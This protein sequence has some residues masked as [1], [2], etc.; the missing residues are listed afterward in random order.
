MDIIFP[1]CYFYTAHYGTSSNGY[2][3]ALKKGL[4]TR[5]RVEGEAVK[6]REGIVTEKLFFPFPFH[7][8]RCPSHSDFTRPSALELGQIA[9][10]HRGPELPTK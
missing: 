3:T 10:S 5:H 9:K 4:L 8:L 7:H 6:E 2:A 1:G